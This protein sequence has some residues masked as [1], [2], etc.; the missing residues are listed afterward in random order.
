M[1]EK[2][3]MN[4]LMEEEDL[5]GLEEEIDNAVDRLFVEKKRGRG[6][7][8]TMESPLEE[9]SSKPSPSEPSIK[10][11][12]FEPEVKPLPL[13][14]SIKPSISEP[15][16]FEPTV[17]AHSLE[18]STE[19]SISEPFEKAV[20][21]EPSFEFEKELE[22]EKSPDAPPA[23][24]VPVP[25]LK[26]IER[27][28]AQLLSLEWEITGEKLKNAKEDVRALKE[29]LKQKADLTAILNNMESVLDHMAKNEDEIQPSW[30][31]F[32]LDSKESLKLLM[33]KERDGEIGIYKQ[34]V[35][36]GIEARFSC[37]EGMKNTQTNQPPLKETVVEMSVAPAAG[38]KK[39][40]EMSK[41]V[42]SFM[43]RV[44][45]I[46]GTMQQ[47]ISRIERAIQTAPSPGVETR[48]PVS[49][50]TIFKVDEKLFGV[51]SE[52]VFKLFK[53]PKTFEEKYSDQQKIRLRNFEVRM[54]DLKKL[55]DIPAREG[56]AK[57]EVRVLTVKEDGGYKGFMVDQVLKKL[58][59]S[60][61]RRGDGEG[62]F[63]GVIHFTYQEQ[64]VEI[65]I[66]D[67]KKF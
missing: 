5:K 33:K 31:K 1:K 35:Y 48:S 36:L 39:I 40:E 38:E 67:L 19:S 22:A 66:L 25:F 55:L 50:I 46:F 57:E 29:L 23:P 58:S 13:E 62:Y 15:P 3:E 43:Q 41:R 14:P 28:E 53:V 8:F 64:P 2:E 30:I 17:E 16:L 42:D 6:E 45:G 47:Q 59:A 61:E 60:S 20:L 10:P 49:N 63:S 56:A 54:V 12:L 18:P 26:A 24:A 51:E 27:M 52:K 34:L 4:K 7:S 21:L 65:P 37:L 44:E 32:L 9:P 11:P